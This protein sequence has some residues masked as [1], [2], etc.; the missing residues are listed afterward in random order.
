MSE[1]LLRNLHVPGCVENSLSQCVTEKMRVNG[2]TRLTSDGVSNI[3]EGCATKRLAISLPRCNPESVYLVGSVV[4]R[5]RYLSN[6]GQKSLL[7][8]HA[9]LVTNS[10]NPA[11]AP[12]VLT[13]LNVTL[14]NIR[15]AL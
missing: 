2:R 3:L 6:R 13:V 10:T 1:D 14:C 4:F 5:A 12:F 11:R 8:P 7:T 15:L 9:P